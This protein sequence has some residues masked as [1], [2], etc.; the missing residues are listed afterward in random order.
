VVISLLKE[1]FN[2][3]VSITPSIYTRPISFTIEVVAFLAKK[4][5]GLSDVGRSASGG[6]VRKLESSKVERVS[7]YGPHP[8]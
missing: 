1:S 7:G 5:E 3:F 8:L 2:T 6:K 4:L